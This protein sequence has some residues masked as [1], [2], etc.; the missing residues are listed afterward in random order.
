MQ[1]NEHDFAMKTVLIELHAGIDARVQ[2]IR[3]NRPEWL[4]AKGCGNCCRQLAE[5]PQLSAAE[6]ERVCT[7]IQTWAKA[8]A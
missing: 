3:E 5:V 6:V 8:G 2:A 7:T 1:F 4:C